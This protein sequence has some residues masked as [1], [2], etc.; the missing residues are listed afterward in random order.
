MHLMLD[1]RPLAPCGLAPVQMPWASQRRHPIHGSSVVY[2]LE[3]ADG[4]IKIGTTGNYSQRRGSLT[5]QH[6]PL[7]LLAWES[8]AYEQ[9]RA[10]HQQFLWERPGKSE[11]FE[12]SAVLIG[13]LEALRVALA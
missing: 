9:E 2:Y 13:H 7:A 11:W 10:R 1:R 12:P 4:M 3:R 6:G 5:R 8:G